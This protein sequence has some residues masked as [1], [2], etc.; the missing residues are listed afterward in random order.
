MAATYG[1]P[2]FRALSRQ[3]SLIKKV[4]YRTRLLTL[5]AALGGVGLHA[6]AADYSFSGY[7]TLGYAKS[8]KPFGYQRFIDDDGTLKRDTVFGAQLDAR[9]ENQIGATVQVKAAPS[10]SSDNKYDA[11]VAWA[12]LSYRPS[13]DWLLRAG[14]L[15][16]PLYLNSETTDIGATFDFARLPTEMYS[17]SPT[18][19]LNGASFRKNWTLDLGELALDGFWGRAN[20]EQ[21][22][23]FRES[24]SNNGVVTPRGPTFEPIKIKASGFAL[25]L[26]RDEGSYR[27]GFNQAIARRANGRPITD[28]VFFQPLDARFPGVGFYLLE[29]PNVPVTASTNN[30]A[31]TLGADVSVGA[32]VRLVGEFARRIVHSDIGPDSS[33]GYLSVLKRISN[34]TV[35]GTYAHLRSTSGPLNNYVKVN[36]NRVPEFIP[37]SKD[38]NASQRAAAGVIQAFDQNSWAMGT[39]YA[40]TNTSKIKAELQRVHVGQVS[41]M[42]DALAGTNVRQQSFNV[43]SFSYS[44]AF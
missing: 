7:G 36:E 41:F 34:W 12:F 1:L 2:R 23:F 27:L 44:F 5:F 37:G 10:L 4:L 11:T 29:G 43:Y 42:V 31:I 6:W 9:F 26:R 22:S 33:G 38:I 21:R 20:I 32:G 40:L 8:D 16:I 19:D 30:I 3:K 35:Y 15:R 25:T 13:N 24:F 17:I 39:S 14:K 18:T 28:R